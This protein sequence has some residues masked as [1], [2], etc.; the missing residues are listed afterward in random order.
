MKVPLLDLPTQYATLQQDVRAAL[1][2]VFNPALVT[3]A[4]TERTW[5]QD[6]DFPLAEHAANETLALTVYPELTDD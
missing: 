3:G 2:R 6:G 4:I 5:P 1:E